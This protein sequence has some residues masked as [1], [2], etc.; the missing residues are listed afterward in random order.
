MGNLGCTSHGATMVI[1]APGF[2]PEV[3]LQ[4]VAAE[5]CTGLYGVPTMFI[6]MQN[7][8]SSPSTTSPPAH[9]DHGRLDL[10]RRGDEALRQRHAHGG[11]VDRLRD[12]GDLARLDP[13]PGRRRPGPSYR[14]HRAGPPARRDQDRRPR[15]RRARR[16]RDDGGVLHPRLLGDARLLA[17]RGR[18][19][20]GRPSTT[21]AGCT[22]ATWPR[23]GRTATASSWAASRTW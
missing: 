7:H 5:R 23:C 3:T 4:A 19:R 8:P 21:R 1:P 17:G 20:P 6:A 12:D 15:E 2:D 16:A 18:R 10:P 11:G 9:G 13:D 14:H 22:P